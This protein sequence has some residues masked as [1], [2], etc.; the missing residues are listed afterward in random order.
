[1]RQRPDPNQI[2]PET[3]LLLDLS[4]DADAARS[5]AM[6]NLASADIRSVAKADLK[7]GSKLEAI[8]RLR[9]MKPGIFVV[10]CPD[11]TTQSATN[12]IQIFGALAG[13]HQVILADPSGK[14]IRCSRYWALVAAPLVLGLQLA[15]GYALL[16]PLAWLATL[17]LEALSPVIKSNASPGVDHAKKGLYL[18]ATPASASLTG[19]MATHVS[20]FTGGAAALG[21]HLDFISSGDL[22]D[23]DPKS[24]VHIIPLSVALSATRALFEL[25]NSITYTIGA[26]RIYNQH[27]RDR[28]WE[29]IYQRYNRFNCAGV[30][31]STFTG[32]PLI[33]E[34]NGSEVWVGGNWD[35]IGMIP[36]VQRFERINQRRADL[37]VVV[38]TAESRNLQAVGVP[39]GRIVVNPNGVDA[40]QFHPGC[41]GPQL[42]DK[43]GVGGKIVV[44]FLGSLGRGTVPKCSRAPW[45]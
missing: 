9:L 14:V 11:L 23:I 21:H 6:R 39:A 17:V 5:W 18:R 38:S 35:P 28:E 12:S 4:N 36:L 7:W 19:G 44:G 42:R 15:L 3:V 26:V 43:L 13:A 25:W 20:G 40:D 2:S 41:G 10:F 8:R 33:L 22:Q 1:L 27:C 30:L 29:F 31:L 32:L 24:Q 37:I 16:A 45:F 34:Y